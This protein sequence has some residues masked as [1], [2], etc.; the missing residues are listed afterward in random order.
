MK[1]GIGILITIA[2]LFSFALLGLAEEK[3][4][5]YRHIT[6][7]GTYSIVG[8]YP[9]DDELAD[10]VNCYHFVYDNIGR[11][12]KVEYLECG[13][14]S[15]DPFFEVAQVSIEYEQGYENRIYL[16]TQDNPTAG[17][18]GV[19]S[20]R[21]KLNENGYPIS[22]FNYNQEGQLVKDIYCVVQYIFTL[23]DKG[24]RIV[25]I[26]CD[27]NGNRIENIYESFKVIKKY[28]KNGNVEE[29]SFYGKEEK[30]KDHKK[31]GVAIIKYEFDEQENIIEESYYEK[32]GKLKERSD[33][34]L[35]IL[36]QK[37]D[38]QGN[39]IEES[40]HEKDGKLKERFDLGMAIFRR[41]YDEQGNMIEESYYGTNEKLIVPYDRDYAIMRKKYNYR[42]N[43]VEISY[44]GIDGY[45]KENENLYFA[46]ERCE[47]DENGNI[48][49][50]GFYGI[51]E[52]LK[53]HKVLGC[54]IIRWKYDENGNRIEIGFYGIDEKLKENKVFGCAII[55]WKYDDYGN[56]LKLTFYDTDD[57]ITDAIGG[58]LF[59][60]TLEVL[61][62][63]SVYA[64][65]V[66]ERKLG[67]AYILFKYDSYENLIKAILYDKYG[68]ELGEA[69]DCESLKIMEQLFY[70]LQFGIM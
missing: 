48:I 27:E 13:N 52:N 44:Y 32:D 58:I 62:P 39:M 49:E 14:L 63:E 4:N 51:D 64:G 18:N 66:Y 9:I 54:A 55:R 12:R 25:T 21:L 68:V 15:I 31:Y 34:G 42:G 47:Y 29:K 38:E 59:K 46:I 20:I 26:F 43:L 23:D 8:R 28:D 37:Y 57:K 17:Y 70:W 53:E 16:D 19:Y 60:E 6:V 3:A 33:L 30:L 10:E 67:C 5:Y 24:R 1:I 45:L 50:I 61:S 11:L 41:K 22:K 69:T 40:Y 2:F 65:K 36:R 35:A 7:D 56:I